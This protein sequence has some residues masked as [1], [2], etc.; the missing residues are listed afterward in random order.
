MSHTSMNGRRSSSSELVGDPVT[1]S[2]TRNPDDIR[3]SIAFWETLS[4]SL[5]V[6]TTTVLTPL[7]SIFSGV[8]ILGAYDVLSPPANTIVAFVAFSLT[9]FVNALNVLSQFS[10][11]RMKSFETALE[12]LNRVQSEPATA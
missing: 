10:K 8:Q 7:A 3:A 1:I 11:K 5:L 4:I 9:I 2:R 12:I 6:F